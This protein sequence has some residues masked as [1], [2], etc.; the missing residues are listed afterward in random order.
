MIMVICGDFV[1]LSIGHLF[2]YMMKR[3][4]VDHRFLITNGTDVR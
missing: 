3:R 1:I 2:R 4:G